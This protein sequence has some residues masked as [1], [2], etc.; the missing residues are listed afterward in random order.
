MVS[1]SNSRYELYTKQRSIDKMTPNQ[2]A[3]YFA[4]DMVFADID[5]PYGR[6]H[7]CRYGRTPLSHCT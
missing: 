3:V 6:Y 4:A 1:R 2:L 5:I 7:C